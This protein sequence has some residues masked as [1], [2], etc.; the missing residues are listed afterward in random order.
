MQHTRKVGQRRIQYRKSKRGASAFDMEPSEYKTGS[1]FAF[2]ICR[3]R[4]PLIYSQP[5]TK[6]YK[7][8]ARCA[9][10]PKQFF[11]QNFKEMKG[12]KAAL[13]RRPGRFKACRKMAHADAGSITLRAKWPPPDDCRSSLSPPN[14]PV[15]TFP[16]AKTAKK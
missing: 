16:P 2:P 15:Q 3:R 4:R 11:C 6:P 9:K 8:A 7:K 1:E 5:A 12:K 13:G 14:A 10:E